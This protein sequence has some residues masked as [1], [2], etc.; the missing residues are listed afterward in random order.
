MIPWKYIGDKTLGA[1]LGGMD[2]RFEQWVTDKMYPPW[3]REFDVHVDVI[4]D[5]PI[6]LWLTRLPTR[7]VIPLAVTNHLQHLQRRMIVRVDSVAVDIW[8]TQ[9]FEKVVEI[10][11]LVLKE[12]TR[13]TFG[14]GFSLTATHAAALTEHVAQL[15]RE[16]NPSPAVFNI[17]GKIELSSPLGPIRKL[18][19]AKNCL[20]KLNG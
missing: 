5:E 2:S 4:R 6:Q 18:F 3:R 7:V 19:D 1:V 17:S 14:V 15:N 16:R 8:L 10:P 11:G 20:I 12:Y 13:N 9:P